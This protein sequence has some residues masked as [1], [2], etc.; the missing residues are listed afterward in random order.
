MG[1]SHL[2]G[3]GVCLL[4]QVADNIVDDHF[5][6]SLGVLRRGALLASSPSLHHLPDRCAASTP[7]K[8]SVS[9]DTA[10][11]SALLQLCIGV[12]IAHCQRVLASAVRSSSISSEPLCM[13]T[14]HRSRPS[15]LATPDAELSTAYHS[16]W[17]MMDSY[18]NTAEPNMALSSQG[19]SNWHALIPSIQ[20]VVRHEIMTLCT[21]AT[22][23]SH[24][25]WNRQLPEGCG[26][27]AHVRGRRM[28]W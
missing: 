21:I 24:V 26:H 16:R 25:I 1:A 5:R 20:T 10:A 14:L 3:L 2:L 6:L 12:I 8:Q 27:A 28:R 15:V 4:E 11:G 23:L 7:D 22:L 13:A 18:T 17:H 19:P 9:A